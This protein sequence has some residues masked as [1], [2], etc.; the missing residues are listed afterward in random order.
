MSL[1]NPLL[2]FLFV[3]FFGLLHLTY[4]CNPPPPSLPNKSLLEVPRYAIQATDRSHHTHTRIGNRESDISRLKNQPPITARYPWIP[5]HG[6]T[7]RET[8]KEREREDGGVDRTN[9]Q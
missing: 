7:D 2:L 1:E 9:V 8:E 6:E 4:L 3:S 5:R